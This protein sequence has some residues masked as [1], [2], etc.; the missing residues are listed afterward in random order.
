MLA[1]KFQQGSFIYIYIYG[2][3]QIRGWKVILRSGLWVLEWHWTGSTCMA[4]SGVRF[5]ISKLAQVARR[6]QWR[7]P[8]SWTWCYLSTGPL[9]MGLRRKINMPKHVHGMITV[10]PKVMCVTVYLWLNW[11]WS[12][13]RLLYWAN[14]LRNM[15]QRITYCILWWFEPARCRQSD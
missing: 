13:D 10:Q 1:G 3:C 8:V 11:S 2:P 12:V 6:S 7:F 14:I 4:M 15:F 9:D 5:W